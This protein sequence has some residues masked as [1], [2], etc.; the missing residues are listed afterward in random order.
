MTGSAAFTAAGNWDGGFYELALEL[1]PGGDARLGRALT[2]L[3]KAAAVPN[4]YGSRDREPHE[5]VPVGCTLDSLRRYRHLRGI[6]TLP[7]GTP[8]VCGLVAIREESG[9][10]WLAFHLPLGALGSADPRVGGFPF[11]DDGTFTHLAWRQPIDN[12]LAD[13]GRQ[14]FA[15]VGYSLGLIGLEAS[16]EAYATDVTDGPPGHRGVGYLIPTDDEIRYWPA[17]R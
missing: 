3:G 1:G 9:I 2:A 10:D 12:W 15:D 14:V 13:I 7:A 4:W 6:A 17:T 16:G 5:Q 11:E 8:V